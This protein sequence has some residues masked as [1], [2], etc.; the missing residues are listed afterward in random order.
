MA[1]AAALQ[2]LPQALRE[3]RRTLAKGELPPDAA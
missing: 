2:A 3:M 1:D